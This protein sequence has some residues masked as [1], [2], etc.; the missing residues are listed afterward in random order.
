MLSLRPLLRWHLLDRQHHSVHQEGS[1]AATLPKDPQEPGFQPAADL[2]PLVH[3]ESAE[4]LHHSMIRQLHQGRHKTA[5]I[6]DCPFT[7]LMDIYNSCCLSRAKKTSRTP[8]T[9]GL[10]CLPAALREVSQAHTRTNTL[11]LSFFPKAI[12]TMNSHVL[13]T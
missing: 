9:L 10:T 1:A 5:Q 2:L 3:R 4:V 11:R 6:I 8:H 7:S 13:A 12:T